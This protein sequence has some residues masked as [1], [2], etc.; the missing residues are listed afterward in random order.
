M[1][2]T[3][4][5]LLCREVTGSST[6]TISN[7]GSQWASFCLL[8]RCFRD[9]LSLLSFLWVYQ[10]PYHSQMSYPINCCW[11]THP[12]LPRMFRGGSLREQQQGWCTEKQS[13]FW[14][15]DCHTGFL[16]MDQVLLLSHY[17]LQTSSC[18]S[19]MLSLCSSVRHT[20]LFHPMQKVF[21]L[22]S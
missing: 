2:A 6:L 7:L 10:T 11:K 9:F 20:L 3:G 22:S 4:L 8:G 21:I 16:R 19:V 13:S 1:E 15:G 12:L 5:L 18:L 14:Y 17:S